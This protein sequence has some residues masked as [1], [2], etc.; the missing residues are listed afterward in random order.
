MK[1]T[2]KRMSP[3]LMALP[4]GDELSREG[5]SSASKILDS[6]T[7]SR[8]QPSKYMLVI[9]AMQK[10]RIALCSVR[11]PRDLH[12]AQTHSHGGIHGH[13][14]VYVYRCIISLF[15]TSQNSP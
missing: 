4:T 13:M 3:A 7:S 1:H 2:T 6:N 15:S 8:M 9:T 5:L 12:A 11:I 10:R 14:I